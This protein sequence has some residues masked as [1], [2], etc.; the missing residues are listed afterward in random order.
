MWSTW[1]AARRI[2]NLSEEWWNRLSFKLVFYCACWP[3]VITMFSAPNYLDAYNNKGA[4]LWYSQDVMVCLYTQKFFDHFRTFG[5]SHKALIH[6]IF[7]TLWMSLHV[8]FKNFHSDFKKGSLPFVTEK[9]LQLIRVFGINF[10]VGQI[11]LAILN[12]MDDEEEEDELETKQELQVCVATHSS[13]HWTS[14][15]LNLLADYW[16]CTRISV[17]NVNC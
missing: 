11:L 16:K 14:W 5:S 12:L 1:S 3:K 8:W 4:V 7:Q 2:Q 17:R 13:S 10:P 15:K 9:G 6:I